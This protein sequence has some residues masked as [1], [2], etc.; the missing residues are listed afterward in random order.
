MIDLSFPTD[1]EKWIKLIEEV[2]SQSNYEI[3]CGFSGIEE[4][5]PAVLGLMKNAPE[6]GI[7]GATYKYL[8]DIA[9]ICINNKNIA[10]NLYIY[11]A[12]GVLDKKLPYENFN[13]GDLI[14]YLDFK[15]INEIHTKD[16]RQNNE[17]VIKKYHEIANSEE[18]KQIN[19]NL[20]DY[21]ADN[22]III[23]DEER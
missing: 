16:F 11:L 13:I 4:L 7:D 1:Q 3:L 5:T 17:E 9:N 20:T 21:L 22:G 8:G 19:K 15:K 18:G 23:I 10:E 14:N 12:N 6:M 2:E